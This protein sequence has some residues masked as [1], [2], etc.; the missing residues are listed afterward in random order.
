VHT[1]VAVT[2]VANLVA[3]VALA[4]L[5]L[6][7]WHRRRAP[8]AGW[9]VLAFGTLGLIVLVGRFIPKHPHGFVESGSV[10]VLV[11][12]LVV[13]PVLLAGFTTAFDRASPFLRWFVASLTTILLVW[14]FA[15]PRFPQAGQPRPW[16]FQAYVIVFVCHWSVLTIVT[17]SRLWRAGRGQPGVSRRRMQWL[18]IACVLIT[19]AIIAAASTTDTNS[20]AT[21]ASGLLGFF[22]AI[23][24]YAGFAPPPLLRAA[25]RR[26]EQRRAQEA[27]QQLITLALT[28]A[29]IGERVVQPMM[30]IVGARA[31]L[32]RDRDGEPVASQ[33][34]PAPGEH[35]ERTRV[36]ETSTESLQ[37]TAWASPYAPFFGDE[38]LR[39]LQ[40]LGALTGIALERVKSYAREHE[41]RLALERANEV[42]ASFIALA[43]HELRT[44]VTTIHGFVRTLNHYAD[45]LTPE[46]EL[47]MRET[48]EE[49]TT[50]MARLVEQLLDLSRLEADAVEIRPE[51]FEIRSRVRQLVAATAGGRSGDVVVEVPDDA[52]ATADANAF[53]RIVSNLVTNA[54]R[55]GQP[56]VTVRLERSDRHLRLAV[57]D[58]GP[59]VPAAFVPDLFERFSRAGVSHDRTPGTGLGLAIARSYAR[60]HGGDLFYESAK[61]HG[62]RFLLVLPADV[63]R[64]ERG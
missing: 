52:E 17:A 58:C 63:T 29:E 48:L 9:L 21:V 46:R 13:F 40:T 14:T 5:A 18:A 10:R 4:A 33:N 54:L 20:P 38:E 53:E 59:G 34:L 3:F 39:I 35:W 51:R 36:I 28:P 60:A 45:R 26:P 32:L 27:I 11:A 42:Q 6:W 55:Y 8:G 49:Q 37:I 43:A 15:M 30:D 22:T 24:F 61:P 25:W 64:L 31:I 19:I 1:T 47:E 7:E 56:P 12:M 50:R 23:A 57:E 44:P 2:G 16:W 41:A 62:A